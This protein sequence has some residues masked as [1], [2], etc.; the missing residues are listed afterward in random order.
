MQP[1]LL[2]YGLT[3]NLQNYDIRAFHIIGEVVDSAGGEAHDTGSEDGI[4]DV[5][6]DAG[7]LSV[8]ERH[9]RS[10][11]IEDNAL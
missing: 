6:D 10:H 8:A 4:G 9:I 7:G 3:F 1:G 11:R 2:G 5:L